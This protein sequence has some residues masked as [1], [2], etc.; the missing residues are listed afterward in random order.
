MRVLAR[1]I[2]IF[3]WPVHL[4]F[5]PFSSTNTIVNFLA[6]PLVTYPVVTVPQFENIYFIP[7]NTIPQMTIVSF[8]AL[9]D[10]G[11]VSIYIHI[12]DINSMVSSTQR[13]PES[14]IGIYRPL[15]ML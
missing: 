2:I 11:N 6:Y 4:L 15:K 3:N 9:I 12:M 5:L 8:V 10:T 14:I 1:I 13:I 7:P